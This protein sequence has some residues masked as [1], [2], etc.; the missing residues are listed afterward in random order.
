MTSNNKTITLSIKY[1]EDDFVCR[2][3]GD[4][5]NDKIYTCCDCETFYCHNCRTSNCINCK[6]IVTIFR[7][8]IVEKLVEDYKTPCDN[9]GCDA[10]ILDWDNIHTLICPFRMIRCEF[11]DKSIST[12]QLIEHLSNHCATKFSVN[13][14]VVNFPLNLDFIND[15]IMYKSDKLTIIVKNNS[16]DKNIYAISNNKQTLIFKTEFEDEKH[17]YKLITSDM[18]QHKLTI[19]HNYI[20]FNID[21]IGNNRVNNI[22]N[23]ATKLI[24][25]NN[26]NDL[27]NTVTDLVK[28]I[29]EERTSTNLDSCK[30]Q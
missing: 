14:I 25:T 12:N 4:F 18:L 27:K 9:D 23:I 2:K 6:K 20:I 21:I 11:C 3:C 28:N 19:P 10:N 22:Y 17:E 1:D 7:N 8:K 15:N 24:N 26:N 13:N 30:T 29:V 5:L 16:L